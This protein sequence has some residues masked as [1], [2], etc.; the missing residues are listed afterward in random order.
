MIFFWFSMKLVSKSWRTLKPRQFWWGN[1]SVSSSTATNVNSFGLDKNVQEL[2][3]LIDK[4]I[5]EVAF[6]ANATTETLIDTASNNISAIAH[7][8]DLKLLGLASAYTPVGWVQSFLEVNH[9][10]L[11]MPWWGT[12]AISTIL[13]RLLAM[14]LSIKAQRGM[15]KLA[16]IRPII[17]PIQE[18][19]ALAKRQG[20]SIQVQIHGQ[21]LQKIFKDHEV[22][23]FSAMAY[24]LGQAPIYLSCFLAL[25][26]MAELPVPGFESGGFSW[27]TDLTLA[28]PYY[29]LPIISCLGMLGSIEANSS[30]NKS[31]SPTAKNVIRVISIAAVPLFGHLPAVHNF[32]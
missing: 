9:V 26:K 28:D 24:S 13:I 23:P 27:V 21:Q 18:K 29:I 4:S 6:R 20:D 32:K 8:G 11:G 5:A 1:S 10:V 3:P 7:F 25:R 2:S 31:Q 17:E 22:N 16:N 12:I 30:M 15:G 14:P 19:M